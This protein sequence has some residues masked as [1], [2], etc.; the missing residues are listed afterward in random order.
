MAGSGRQKL[1]AW[2]GD[3][4]GRIHGAAE[5]TIR[6]VP[7]LHSATR[8]VEEI[9][10]AEQTRRTAEPVPGRKNSAVRPEVPLA[11]DRRP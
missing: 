10:A 5:I 7:A 8:K 9:D 4:V 3:V 1:S 6:S 2:S 11:E